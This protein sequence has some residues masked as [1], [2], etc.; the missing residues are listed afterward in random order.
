VIVLDK[1]PQHINKQYDQRGKIVQ[2]MLAAFSNRVV[3]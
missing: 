3:A 2:V 1:A